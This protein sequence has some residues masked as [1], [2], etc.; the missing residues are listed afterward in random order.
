MAEF[1]DTATD[2]NIDD[3]LRWAIANKILAR[4]FETCS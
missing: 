2:E 1:L 3:N 4:I